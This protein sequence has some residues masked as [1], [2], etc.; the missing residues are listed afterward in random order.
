[1]PVRLTF[2][3]YLQTEHENVGRIGLT[4]V[5]AGLVGSFVGGL[6]LSWSGNYK[7]A[8]LL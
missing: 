7:Y 8:S 6:W 4:I 5:L 3:L 1:M 2:D